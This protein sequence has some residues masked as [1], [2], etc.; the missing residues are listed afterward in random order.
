[1]MDAQCDPEQ[2]DETGPANPGYIQR[3]WRTARRTPAD[4]A[5]TQIHECH[6]RLRQMLRDMKR[7]KDA[8]A[9]Q[10]VH[11]RSSRACAAACAS[12]A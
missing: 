12:P 6:S 2:G 5:R 3:P 10:R 8:D 9:A 4:H 7:R 11:L 1:M